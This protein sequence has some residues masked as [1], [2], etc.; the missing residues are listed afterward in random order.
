MFMCVFIFFLFM[1]SVFHRK[2]WLLLL[3]AISTFR[4]ICTYLFDREGFIITSTLINFEHS[5]ALI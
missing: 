2:Y 5:S 1:N 3:F 4:Y